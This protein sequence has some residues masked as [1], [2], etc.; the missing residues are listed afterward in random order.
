MAL[1]LLHP[2]QTESVFDEVTN[3]VIQSRVYPNSR[4]KGAYLF[5]FS[6]IPIPADEKNSL[7]KKQRP[8]CYGLLQKKDRSVE[9][10]EINF[11]PEDDS[12]EIL[13]MFGD[14]LDIGLHF[15][16]KNEMNLGTGY[17]SLYGDSI[18]DY[19]CTGFRV[20]I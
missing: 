18:S 7:L 14:I 4:T 17:A 9:Y 12:S 1:P 13:H 2:S 20:I 19:D 16:K 6:I 11:D 5:N 15:D 10:F 8:E 3:L